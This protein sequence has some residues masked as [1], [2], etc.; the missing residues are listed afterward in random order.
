[1]RAGVQP[2][3]SYVRVLD[4]IYKGGLRKERVRAHQRRDLSRLMAK[5]MSCSVGDPHD[6]DDNIHALGLTA[7]VLVVPDTILLGVP[8]CASGR[9]H[10]T[11]ADSGGRGSC[12]GVGASR[13]WVGQVLDDGGVYSALVLDMKLAFRDESGQ[14]RFLQRASESE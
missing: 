6:A 12:S 1:M 14:N 11:A 10:S 8:V 9:V 2:C 3:D 5:R 4:T 13:T 7:L